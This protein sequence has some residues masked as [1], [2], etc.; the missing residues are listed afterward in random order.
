MK[1]KKQNTKLNERSKQIRRE[2]LK[3]SK[4]N[5]GYHYGGSFSAVEILISLYDHILKDED[6][7][8]LSK[9]H[10]CWPYY[11]LLRERGFNPKLE[12]HPC[13]DERNGV[14][15]T[16]GSEG[17]G[18]PTGIGMAMARK[19]KGKKGRIYVLLGDGECQE[20]TT[21]ESLLTA[22]HRKL[23]NL[24]AIVD[25][26]GIQGAGF[27]KDNL[28]INGFGKIAEILGWSVTEI[29]GHSFREIIVALK[30]KV[31]SKPRMIIAH[32]IK[33]KGVS[34]MENKPEWHAKWPNEEQEKQAF[35]ELE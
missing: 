31:K 9:G 5:G 29:D 26:N 12:G 6:K 33:G 15:C 16:T 23:D 11:V 8:I 30:K 7:F 14:H 2:T 17:H 28:P 13:L 25:Y 10:A 21:W 3:L 22:P 34:Y 4:A 20:G 1:H 32:T 35:M 24:T 18:L 19:I 27:V